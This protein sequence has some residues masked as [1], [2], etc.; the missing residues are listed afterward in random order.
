MTQ[1]NRLNDTGN[2]ILNDRQA[3]DRQMLALDALSKLARQFSNKP[4]FEKL[5]ELLLLTLSGQFAVANSFA[6]FYKNRGYLRGR[7]FFAGGRYISNPHLAALEI[8]EE[9]EEYFLKYKGPHKVADVALGGKA[10]GL[11]FILSEHNV[12]IIAPLIHG[13]KLIGL[14]GLGRKVNQKTFDDKELELLSTLINSIIPFIAN[15]FL[16][17]E[18]SGLNTWYLNILNSVKQGVFVFGPDRLLRQINAAG[19]EILRLFKPNLPNIEALYQIPIELIFPEKIFPGWASRLIRDI[20][21]GT[22]KIYDNMTAGFQDISR[23]FNLKVGHLR[24]QNQDYSDIIITLDDITDQTE[25]EQRLFNLEKFAEKG[26]MASAIAHELNN[27]L[28]LILG[29]IE[30][31]QLALSKSNLEK[32]VTT[33]AKLIENVGQMSRFTA[34]LTDYTRLE[35]QKQYDNLNRIITDVLAFVM[36]QKKFRNI[37]IASELDTD[38]PPI[39]IDR[40][41]IAQLLLNFLNN[42]A[43]AIFEA[44]RKEGQIRVKTIHHSDFA[45]M[46][47]SDNGI[48]IAPEVKNRLFK[49]RLTTKPNG[50]GY[51]LITCAKIIE[52]HN[53]QIEINSEPGQG[54]EFRFKFPQGG[55]SAEQ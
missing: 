49:A 4:D 19:Y 27:H 47:I 28:G 32:A 22:G 18:I 40:D 21:S 48:G 5:I 43:D 36:V 1:E 38:L 16:F 20:D 52:N 24:S 7:N 23:I 50:H 35:T 45:E 12:D 11:L 30:M 41:Q 42:S 15:S 44:G 33:L 54:A 17:M 29:G 25:N 37:N 51:G 2:V 34:G 6:L 46:T 53:G 39:M 55:P 26:Q 10:G 13:N 14:L 8:S 9:H 31:T 3:A